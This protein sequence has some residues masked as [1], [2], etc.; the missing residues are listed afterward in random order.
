MK[1]TGFAE[2]ELVDGLEQLAAYSAHSIQTGPDAKALITAD[3]NT[4]SSATDRPGGL[5]FAASSENGRVLALGD[6]HFPHQSVLHGLRQ[7][8][9]YRQHRRF[10]D[11]F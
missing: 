5:I 9:V 8:P 11:C 1:G 10:F 4:W 7:Q 3:E 2:D 6:V